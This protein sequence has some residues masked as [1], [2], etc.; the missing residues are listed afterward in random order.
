LATLAILRAGIEYKLHGEPALSAANDPC[1]NGPLAFS[2]FTFE[3]VDRGFQLSSAFNL[4]RN[5]AVLIFV[6]K[7]GPP[8][9]VDGNYPGRPLT[10]VAP[11]Q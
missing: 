8:F 7:S 11:G 9:Q 10:Q 5:Q 3:G 2:R 6:E 1:G 4:G